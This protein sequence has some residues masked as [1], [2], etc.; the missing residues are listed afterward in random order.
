MRTLLC[1]SDWSAAES[2]QDGRSEKQRICGSRV[3]MPTCRA[4][5]KISIAHLGHK[6]CGSLSWALTLCDSQLGRNAHIVFP[7]ATSTCFYQIWVTPLEDPFH[8]ELKT[9]FVLLLWTLAT[10]RCLPSPLSCCFLS[11]VAELWSSQMVERCTG[12]GCAAGQRGHRQV[13]CTKHSAWE[14]SVKICMNARTDQITLQCYPCVKRPSILLC[15]IWRTHCMKPSHSCFVGVACIQQ[16]Q[17]QIC[18]G[19]L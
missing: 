14:R 17:G 13:K 1:A 11:L 19:T 6:I 9:L 5:N 3:L 7:R 10:S 12:L 4:G 18:W 15:T 8:L 2:S 16:H